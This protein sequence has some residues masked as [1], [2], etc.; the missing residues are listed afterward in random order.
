VRGSPVFISE[1]IK[2]P[3]IAIADALDA[4]DA[5]GIKF[6]I[7]TPPSGIIYG[8]KMVD[9]DKESIESHLFIFNKEIV[10]TAS[11]AAFA[12]TDVE[13]TLYYVGMWDFTTWETTSAQATSEGNATAPSPPKLF[14]TSIGGLWCQLVTRG[15]PTIAAGKEPY[16]QLFILPD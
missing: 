8:A 4:N 9:P 7:P 3:G 15:A 14:K 13:M 2:V 1:P 16:I 6:F 10:G 5:E 11:D 12:P